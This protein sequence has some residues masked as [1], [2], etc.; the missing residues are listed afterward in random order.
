MPQAGFSVTPPPTQPQPTM[1]M[2]TFQKALRWKLE[3]S[4]VPVEIDVPL[5]P[6]PNSAMLGFAPQ[7]YAP[8]G[9][10]PQGSAGNFGQQQKV[11]LLLYVVTAHTVVL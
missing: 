6:P 7:G 3:E 11:I 5:T 10:A 2:T 9:Y 4:V 1:K 8:Q